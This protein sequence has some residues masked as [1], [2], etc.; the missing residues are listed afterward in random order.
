MIFDAIDVDGDGT[1]SSKEFISGMFLFHSGTDDEKLQFLFNAFD[2]DGSGYLTITEVQEMLWESAIK[3]QSLLANLFTSTKGEGRDEKKEK[4]KRRRTVEANL[5][6][7]VNAEAQRLFE[8]LD[9]NGD[10]KISFLEWMRG[11][12]TNKIMKNWLAAISANGPS[13][14]VQDDHAPAVDE[15]HLFVLDISTSG[16]SVLSPQE[17]L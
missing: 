7:K 8:E 12:R 5:R 9:T 14:K 15:D 13:V 3:S 17:S 6:P 10:K 1:L 2:S 16:S 11:S 4:K